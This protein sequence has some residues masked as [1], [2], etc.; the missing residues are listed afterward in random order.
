MFAETRNIV[1]LHNFRCM[2]F[3]EH[4]HRWAVPVTQFSY[5]F[6]P[7]LS[8]PIS[9]STPSVVYGLPTHNPFESCRCR[10][11]FIV[12]VVGF[13]HLTSSHVSRHQ[14]KFSPVLNIICRGGSASLF[15]SF[16]YFFFFF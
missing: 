13:W 16:F 8:Q 2:A 3:I 6:V 12:R 4:R 1:K 5:Y 10:I 11:E 9:L 7:T 15:S 14:T